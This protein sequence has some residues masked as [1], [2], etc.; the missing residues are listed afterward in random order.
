MIDPLHDAGVR[1]AGGGQARG[2]QRIVRDGRGKHAVDARLHG[3]RIPGRTALRAPVGDGVARGLGIRAAV[4]VV[5]G[6]V[7]TGDRG[8]AK[9]L[10]GD[11]ELPAVG[12]VS[13]GFAHK[14]LF[15]VNG[16]EPDR[17]FVFHDR[18]V[19]IDA[20]AE[21][22]VAV[23]A[24]LEVARFAGHVGL[25]EVEVHG[26]G[27]VA[28]AEDVRVGAAADF[29][30]VHVVSVDGQCARP[31]ETVARNVRRAEAANAVGGLRVAGHVVVNP[32]GVGGRIGKLS[33]ALCVRLV[34]KDVVNIDRRGVH[35]LLLRDDRDG[36]RQVFESRVHPR[37]GQR[38]GGEIA[39]VFL[40]FDLERRELHDLV[41]PRVLGGGVQGGNCLR[42][43]GLLGGKLSSVEDAVFVLVVFGELRGCGSRGVEGWRHLRASQWEGEDGKELGEGKRPQA[44]GNQSMEVH[45]GGLLRPVGLVLELIKEAGGTAFGLRCAV[46]PFCQGCLAW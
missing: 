40:A 14:A 43:I 41:A 5:V 9:R 37:A 27:G 22:A 33:R 39:F 35:E 1:G 23:A 24:Q 15:L 44:L 11:A 6:L 20:G 34:E 46:A 12:A 3:H 21:A 38:A 19:E 29:H 18:T 30:R 26:A 7:G 36:C 28:H 4:E 16:G 17:Q 13:G 10:G 25:G 8:I 42:L 32:A 45:G 2:Q 31:G